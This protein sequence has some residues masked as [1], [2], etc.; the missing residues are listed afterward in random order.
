MVNGIFVVRE[1]WDLIGNDMIGGE[2]MDG[3]DSNSVLDHA[4]AL[5]VAKGLPPWLGLGS[6]HKPC[7]RSKLP[8]KSRRVGIVFMWLLK[9]CHCSNVVEG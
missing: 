3:I 7:F 1:T 2:N 9:G 5:E 6:F 4:A 8:M